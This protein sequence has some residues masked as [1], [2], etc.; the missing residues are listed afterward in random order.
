M[1][2]QEDLSFF[3]GNCGLSG[4]FLEGD[5][6]YNKMWG[7]DYIVIDKQFLKNSEIATMIEEMTILRAME[8]HC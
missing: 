7:R 4:F 1:S 8:N 6:K 5:S 3:D 2:G